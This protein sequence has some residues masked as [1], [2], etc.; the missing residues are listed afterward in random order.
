[1]NDIALKPIPGHQSY[2]ASSDGRVWSKKTGRWKPLSGMDG[3]GSRYCRVAIKDGGKTVWKYV[4][5]LVLAAFLGDRPGMQCRHL[6]GNKLNNDISNL[7]W[8]TARE[9]SD[10]MERHGARC[11]GS[12][13]ANSVLC[14]RDVA[15][16]RSLHTRGAT[17]R[18]L[19]NRFGVSFQTAS[20]VVRGKGWKHVPLNQIAVR[21][22]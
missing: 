6:D 2:A 19:A 5:R 1:M 12:R 18:S 13:I 3:G 14:E 10:D 9:N 4:H 7:A 16:M 21:S 11:R 20:T 22:S 17:I 8:G 15:E